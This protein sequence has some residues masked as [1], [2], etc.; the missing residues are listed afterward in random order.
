MT[1]NKE[2]ETPTKEPDNKETTE[3]TPQGNPSPFSLFMAENCAFCSDNKKC[4]ETQHK[5]YNIALCL[6]IRDL[7]EKQKHNQI[8]TNQ[9]KE[10]FSKLTLELQNALN[11]PNISRPQKPLPAERHVE[12]GI[13]WLWDTNKNG[14]PYERALESENVESQNYRELKTK[15]AEAVQAGKKGFLHQDKWCFLS[16]Q[17]NWIG[18]KEPKTFEANKQ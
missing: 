1:T 12:Y 18:R 4:F 15:L 14:E 6:Q 8:L 11:R 5:N 13:T 9:M 7:Q 10:Y 2:T 3:E 17:Q 16:T